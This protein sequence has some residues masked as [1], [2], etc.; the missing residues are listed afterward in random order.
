MREVHVIEAVCA[1]G[2]EQNTMKYLAEQLHIT[3]GSLT[4]AANTLIRKGYLT[5][6]QDARDRRKMHLVPT[7]K[8]QA[9]DQLHKDY[10]R[11]LTDAIIHAVPADQMD[12]FL[13]GLN[14]AYDYVRKAQ[15]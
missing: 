7:E 1:A 5:R 6:E 15:V 3:I 13:S 10:H 9:I 2:S 12:T 14:G 11:K 4:V 8:A